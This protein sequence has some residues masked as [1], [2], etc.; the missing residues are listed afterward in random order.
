M[1]DGFKKG[2]SGGWESDLLA[3]AEIG[4]SPDEVLS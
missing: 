2:N 3:V 4:V 1:E